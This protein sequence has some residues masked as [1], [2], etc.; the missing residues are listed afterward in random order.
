[1]TE[2]STTRASHWTTPETQRRLA[3]RHASERRF[4]Q[5][6]IAAIGLAI[7]CLLVLVGSVLWNGA[8][9]FWRTEI[10]VDVR[11]DPDQ[12]GELSGKTPE[13]V[14]NTLRKADFGAVLPRRWLQ[15]RGFSAI[16]ALAA[17]RGPW[18]RGLA[19][20]NALRATRGLG[21]DRSQQRLEQLLDPPRSGGL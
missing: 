20:T 6:G 10:L 13:E 18:M 12:I 1:M 7:A 11:F 19:E 15:P 4:R 14:E 9:A 3:K 2:E 8:S 16:L 5:A 21:P 17:P